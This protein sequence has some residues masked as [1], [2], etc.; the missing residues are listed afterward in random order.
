MYEL[1]ATGVLLLTTTIRETHLQRMLGWGRKEL[2][3][4]RLEAGVVELEKMPTEGGKK[5]SELQIRLQ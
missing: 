4:K 3:A 5:Q 1:A 2:G